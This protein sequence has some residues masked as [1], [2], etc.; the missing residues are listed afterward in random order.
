MFWNWSLYICLFVF[1]SLC[2]GPCVGSRF[3]PLWWGQE[4]ANMTHTCI[5][6]LQIHCRSMSSKLSL[7]PAKHRV[8]NTALGTAIW[9]LISKDYFSMHVHVCRIDNGWVF[10]WQERCLQGHQTN[11][12]NRPAL[13]CTCFLWEGL[14]CKLAIQ[15]SQLKS[16]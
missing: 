4:S 12:S 16:P 7:I 8:F 3:F 9:H 13:V 2:L 14:L 6:E 10:S 11:L 5:F 15:I 1:G